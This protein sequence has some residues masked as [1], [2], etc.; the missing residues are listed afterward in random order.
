MMV[1]KGVTI[2]TLFFPLLLVFASMAAVN[3]SEL[4][5]QTLSDPTPGVPSPQ[6]SNAS[7]RPPIR[8]MP[9]AEMPPN[10]P[11]VNCSGGQLTIMAENSTMGSVLAAVR[12]CI[13]VTIEIPDGASAMR[14]YFNA[15]PGPINEVLQSLLSSTDLDYVIQSSSSNP[16]KI[17]AVLLIA[18]LRDPKDVQAPSDHPLTPTRRAWLESRRNARSASPETTEEATP[19][20]EEPVVA[21]EAQTPPP[22]SKAGGAIVTSGT[23]DTTDK[24]VPTSTATG[25]GIQS[26]N[27]AVAVASGDSPSI[28]TTTP[29]TPDPSANRPAV[30]ETQ[31]K[32]TSMEQM[33]EQRKQM[34]ESQAT[35][36][37]Q[38]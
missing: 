11:K 31:Q 13:G 24:P 9:P 17:Q 21:T 12:S 32:I 2:L 28:D 20:D 35:T 29:T 38:P 14:M 25:D 18:R 7:P 36:P 27:A 33:F 4:E 26:S 5:A 3:V 23:M 30:S 10:P 15:G 8:V 19:V 1:T 37:K 22:S 16:G 34:L 6:D